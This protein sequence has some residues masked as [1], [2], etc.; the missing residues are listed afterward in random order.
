VTGSRMAK[1]ETSE[2]EKVKCFL[3]QNASKLQKAELIVHRSAGQYV[4]ELRA[5]RRDYFLK[6]SCE[7]M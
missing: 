3:E 4:V 6:C 5:H 7:S 2:L 1:L